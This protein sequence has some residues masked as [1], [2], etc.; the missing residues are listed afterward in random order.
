MPYFRRELTWEQQMVGFLEKRLVI[1]L[2]GGG[3]IG[4]GLE[5]MAAATKLVRTSAL[6]YKTELAVP[7]PGGLPGV[8]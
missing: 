2:R 1:P 3:A 6:P 7:G 4:C 8:P 5:H